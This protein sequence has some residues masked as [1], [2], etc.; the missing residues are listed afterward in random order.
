MKTSSQR[1]LQNSVLLAL[2]AALFALSATAEVTSLVN[3]QGKL[4]K[5]GTNE[6]GQINITFKIFTGETNNECIYEESQQVNVVDGL[7][8]TLI[9]KN[10]TLGAI[11]EATKE[12]NAHLEVIINGAA[13]KPREKFTPPPFA[14]RT[15]RVLRPSGGI[16]HE[17]SYS[18]HY[19]LYGT[20]GGWQYTMM[21]RSLGA[22]A[23]AAI[24]APET[25]T[26]TV[27]SLKYYPFEIRYPNPADV[28]A[29]VSAHNATNG[30]MRYLSQPFYFNLTNCP[31]HTWTTIP[32]S[33]NAAD[34]I[35]YPGEFTCF[36]FSSTFPEGTTYR[37]VVTAEMQV[38]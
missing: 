27:T 18:K 5:H 6:N 35:L 36:V 2:L 26:N 13:L 4:K 16:W 33:S 17:Y 20:L 15:L 38:K 3:Y 7:Y 24:F 29:R 22:V 37:F 21:E 34:R 1:L 25:I 30:L 8:S 11:E 19:E 10:P 23:C 9:G 32:L 14:K 12:D 31:L 28:Q